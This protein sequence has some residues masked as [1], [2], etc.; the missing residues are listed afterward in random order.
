MRLLYS[1]NKFH[2]NAITRTTVRLNH[3]LRQVDDDLEL[4][5][6]LIE[7]ASASIYKKQNILKKCYLCGE[8]FCSERTLTHRFSTIEFATLVPVPHK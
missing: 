1:F 5:L 2:C 4:Y 3:F 8:S 6:N 7:E